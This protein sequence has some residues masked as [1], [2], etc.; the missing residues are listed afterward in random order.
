[1]S[2]LIKNIDSLNSKLKNELIMS[3]T[4]LENL[5]DSTTGGY[6]GDIPDYIVEKLPSDKTQEDFF[7]MFDSVVEYAKKNKFD[8]AKETINNFFDG[9]IVFDIERKYFLG[10]YIKFGIILSNNICDEKLFVKIFKDNYEELHFLFYQSGP[11]V[12]PAVAL[13]VNSHVDNFDCF[14]RFYFANATKLYMVSEYVKMVYDY[15]NDLTFKKYQRGVI[16][17]LSTMPDYDEISEYI[18]EG[19]EHITKIRENHY[20]MLQNMAK[21]KFAF[22]DITKENF[23]ICEDKTGQK[24]SK[25]I[26]Y[27]Q[28]FLINN[29]KNQSFNG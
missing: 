21:G 29:D 20:K 24:H 22:L 26:D 1:M 16:R 25:M 18:T 15:S 27:G 4:E 17:K 6:L 28:I 10:R 23:L 19:F 14:A 9:K 7:H 12:E 3:L 8:L 5:I 11:Y 2:D 13:F